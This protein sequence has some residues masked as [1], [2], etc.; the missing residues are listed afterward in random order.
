MSRILSLDEARSAYEGALIREGAVI[1]EGVVIYEGAIIREGAIIGCGR[2]YVKDALVI[3][4]IGS[5]KNITAY[6]CDDGVIINI[7]CMNSYRGN[8]VEDTIKEIGLKYDSD[9]VYFDAI[10]LIKKFYGV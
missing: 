9:H 10:N 4:G 2:K 3:H 8:T 1:C 5:T 6:R 7:G